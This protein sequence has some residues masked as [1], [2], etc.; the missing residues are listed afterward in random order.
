MLPLLTSVLGPPAP[1]GA[2]PLGLHP[3]CISVVCI[4]FLS[5]QKSGRSPR[6]L[7]HCME[8][9]FCKDTGLC[10]SCLGSCNS[11]SAPVPGVGM[12]SLSSPW[13]SRQDLQL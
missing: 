13:V 3:R 4:V 7:S 6:V 2:G 8:N 11:G 12:C 1:G 10:Q 5:V 9:T